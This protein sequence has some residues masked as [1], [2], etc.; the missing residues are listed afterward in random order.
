MSDRRVIGRVTGRHLGPLIIGL[1]G[2]H[3]DEPAGVEAL[4]H[5]LTQLTPVAGKLG[6]EFV[7]VAGNMGALQRRRR[8][9]DRDLNRC[10]LPEQITH[11]VDHPDASLTAED[12]EQQ[13]LLKLL[14]RLLANRSDAVLLDLH[15]T[16]GRSNPFLIAPVDHDAWL[17]AT[18]GIPIVHG[19][20]RFVTGTLAAY[21]SQL[22]VLSLAVEGGQHDD[23]TAVTYLS[24]I[25]L[26]AVRALGMVKDEAAMRDWR[27]SMVR[28]AARDVSGAFEVTYCHRIRQDDKFRMVPGF[29]NFQ[30]VRAEDVLAR[31]VH[32]P[33]V[34]PHDGLLLMPL[35]RERGEEGFFLVRPQ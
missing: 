17:G 26:L 23:P 15:T 2:L 22:G 11:L 35:Y 21:T 25:V 28:E 32:G 1:G 9:I 4:N 29:R 33:V 3:G 13:E 5:V 24:G 10:W 27:S 19:L 6:G 16:S 8:F 31:D 30:P 7:A 14:D 34:A 20:A 18:M 12:R